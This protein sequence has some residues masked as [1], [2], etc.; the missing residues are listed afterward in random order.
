MNICIAIKKYLSDFAA[1][2][3][4]QVIQ[5]FLKDASLCAISVCYCVNVRSNSN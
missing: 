5:T 2:S 4:H 3:I 1:V